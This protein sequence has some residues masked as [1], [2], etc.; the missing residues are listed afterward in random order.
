MKSLHSL[1]LSHEDK[2]RASN[3]NPRFEM[4]GDGGNRTG[5]AELQRKTVARP[6]LHHYSAT[7]MRGGQR[8]SP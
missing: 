3:G 2:P 1:L 6:V 8:R 4:C 7:S 5:V